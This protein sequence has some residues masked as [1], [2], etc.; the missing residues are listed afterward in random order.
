MTT[1]Y[2]GNLPYDAKDEDLKSLFDKYDC[3]SAVMQRRYDGRPKGFALATV[4]KADEAIAEL[5]ETEFQGRKIM[6]RLDKGPTDKTKMDQHR[7]KR[8]EEAAEPSNSV[9]VGNLPYDVT[10]EQ[11]ATHFPGA[12]SAVV[13]SGRDGRS[14]GYA[15]VT[16]D[17]IENAQAAINEKNDE[18]VGGRKVRCRFNNR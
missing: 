9:F 13:Q 8:N 11:L 14:R 4:G 10:S 18:E 16:Y 1:L 12:Q 15:V 17:S 2:V 3:S 5:N 6:V 7:K